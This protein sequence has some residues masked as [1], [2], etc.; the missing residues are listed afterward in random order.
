MSLSSGREFNIEQIVKISYAH[1]RID[2]DKC[3]ALARHI[4]LL[5][6]CH[7]HLEYHR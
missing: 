3:S 1:T 2:T 6:W 7:I 4:P 5:R